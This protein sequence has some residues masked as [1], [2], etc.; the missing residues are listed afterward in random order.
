MTS[1]DKVTMEAEGEFRKKFI[2]QTK[3]VAVPIIDRLS[4]D[5]Q[6]HFMLIHEYKGIRI[7][8]PDGEERTPDHPSEADI[9]GK[10][11]LLITDQRILYIVGKPGEEDDKIQEFDYGQITSVEGHQSLT[12]GADI[13]EFTTTDGRK[14]KFANTAVRTD[15]IENMVEYIDMQITS[16]TAEA[17][18]DPTSENTTGR[19]S[20]QA[21]STANSSEN[22]FCPDCGAKVQTGDTFCTECGTSLE[23]DV[24]NQNNT[25][26]SGN[27]YDREEVSD[28]NSNT[29]G[30]KSHY[31]TTVWIASA[32]VGVI[33]FP[34]GMLVPAYFY[35][36]ASKGTGADQTPLEVWTVILIG[37]IGIAV[38]EIGGRKGA[39]ILWY[40]FAAIILLIII[41]AL[42]VA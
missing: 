36:K 29:D 39:K 25:G 8:E 31:S 30:W 4:S 19:E 9:E 7:F 27:V 16:K 14:Y 34:L 40:I 22:K 1:A 21:T 3:S 38:V 12:Q 6:L 5:E 41:L 35:Y 20:G 33:T 10:R 13:I 18:G 26:E 23:R 2:T 24:R 28:T 32:I 15:T 42:A 17:S 11:F 37:F